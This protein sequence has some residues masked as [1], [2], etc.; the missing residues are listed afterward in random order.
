MIDKVS[1]K[2]KARAKAAAPKLKLGDWD[3]LVWDAFVAGDE[4]ARI[5]ADLDQYVQ[6]LSDKNL[7]AEEYKHNAI[8]E[9]RLAVM[10]AAATARGVELTEKNHNEA[11]ASAKRNLQEIEKIRHGLQKFDKNKFASPDQIG[12]VLAAQRAPL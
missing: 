9:F 11:I 1:A 8:L 4:N 5:T 10:T 6:I 7:I 3:A 2:L 12:D